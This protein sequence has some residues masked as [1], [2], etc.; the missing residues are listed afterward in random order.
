MRLCKLAA[1][2]IAKILSIFPYLKGM[3]DFARGEHRISNPWV[4][5]QKSAANARART[6]LKILPGSPG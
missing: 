6:A 5:I 4:R 1:G 3:V 2:N